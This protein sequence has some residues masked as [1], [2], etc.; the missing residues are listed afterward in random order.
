MKKCIK[1]FKIIF[2]GGTRSVTDYEIQEAIKSS[3]IFI[4]IADNP[5]ETFGLSLLNA[6][7]AG[8]PIIASD[9]SGYKDIVYMFCFPKDSS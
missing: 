9:W 4:S 1:R 3:D 2:I 7:V 5:Q 6:L 8:T